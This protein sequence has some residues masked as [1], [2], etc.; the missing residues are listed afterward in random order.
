MWKMCF[1]F[2]FWSVKLP[3]FVDLSDTLCDCFPDSS[4]EKEE[5]ALGQYFEA[6]ILQVFLFFF[7]SQFSLLWHCREADDK[8]VFCK[9]V[10][11]AI[12]GNAQ[13]FF[14]GDYFNTMCNN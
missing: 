14:L 7:L 1:I 4:W 10:F 5:D 3:E 2:I 9:T 12:K 8:V 13:N 6:G 11:E